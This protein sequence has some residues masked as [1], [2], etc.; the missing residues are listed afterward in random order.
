M[1]GDTTES[2]RAEKPGRQDAERQDSAAL[3]DRGRDELLKTLSDP[4]S[5]AV[6]RV[7]SAEALTAAELSERLDLP[8]STVYR[9]VDRL[10][11]ASLIEGSR[12][13]AADGKHPRQYRCIVER[14]HVE[15]PGESDMT[16]YTHAN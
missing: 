12:R 15:L 10:L 9:K 2:R 3:D 7:T 5:R 14:V 16:V 8:L 1:H 11:D 6:L 4:K 13:I